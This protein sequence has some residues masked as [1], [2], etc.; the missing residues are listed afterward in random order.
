MSTTA[1]LFS[2]LSGFKGNPRVY[3]KQV[4]GEMTFYFHRHHNKRF[5]KFNWDNHRPCSVGVRF[6]NVSHQKLKELC[7]GEQFYV[8]AR[9]E[10]V[11]PKG[12][13]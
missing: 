4:M 12:A 9:V 3:V 5:H 6:K 8:E 10:I 13:S 1:D 11:A 2:I 7:H